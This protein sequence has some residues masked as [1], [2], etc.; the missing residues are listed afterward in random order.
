M[1]N[2]IE[3]NLTRT[4]FSKLLSENIVT[5]FY[6]TGCTDGALA[7]ALVRSFF[8]NLPPDNPD[9]K[10]TI[11]PIQYGDVVSMDG[12]S[13]GSVAVFVDFTPDIMTRVLMLKR[14]SKLVVID[15]HYKP[16]MDM[17]RFIDKD[18]TDPS[19]YYY[20]DTDPKGKSNSG[21]SLVM[22][23]ITLV[24]TKEHINSIME[25]IKDAKTYDL[26]LH[27]ADLTSRAEKL[28]FFVKNTKDDNRTPLDR[29][30]LLVELDRDISFA[31]E[32][33]A[34][35]AKDAFMSIMNVIMST[36]F[37]AG[38]NNGI[39]ER[40]VRRLFRFR[41]KPIFKDQPRRGFKVAH[42]MAIRSQRDHLGAFLQ[43]CAPDADF[44]MTYS[45][46]ERYNQWIYSLR[47]VKDDV[48]CS[49]IASHF[50]GNGHRSA[51]GFKTEYGP[52]EVL[53][54]FCIDFEGRID[55]NAVQQVA[56]DSLTKVKSKTN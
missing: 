31:Y 28:N 32:M 26:W 37:I 29:A 3:T 27:D 49:Y 13:S 11:R 53:M 22:D 16:V 52:R 20:V 2:H 6:H 47:T 43:R 33:G 36:G 39:L 4:L 34:E 17:L 7:G 35:M 19:I 14:C 8:N 55:L 44:T 56:I 5:V 50:E 38:A 18:S 40:T 10:I 24:R 23:L 9:R 42:C 46:D 25:V 41:E 54:A 21:A 15:H 30:S 48:D 45:Y 12:I 51:A 1:V